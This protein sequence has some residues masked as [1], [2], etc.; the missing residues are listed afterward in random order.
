M[1][2][3]M[4]EYWAVAGM[5]HDIDYELYPEEHCKTSHN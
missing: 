5:L 3:E 1:N 4:E 2:L